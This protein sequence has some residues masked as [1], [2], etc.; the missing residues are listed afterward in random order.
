MYIWRQNHGDQRLTS[1]AYGSDAQ[2]MRKQCFPSPIIVPICLPP[3]VR[4]DTTKP[5]FDVIHISLVVAYIS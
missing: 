5:V 2:G 4:R 3:E 1:A